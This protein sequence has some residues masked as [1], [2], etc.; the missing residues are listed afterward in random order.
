MSKPILELF[1]LLVAPTLIVFFPYEILRRNSNAGRRI[2]AGYE[3]EDQLSQ[4]SCAM[5]R[6]IEYVAKSLKVT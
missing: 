1:H 3:Q 4:R 2:Q 5:H 6:V